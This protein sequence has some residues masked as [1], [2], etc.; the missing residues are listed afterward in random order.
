[1]RSVAPQAL[2]TD[3]SAAHRP[4]TEIRLGIV[5][6]M[7]NEAATAVRFVE[8]V[9]AECRRHELASVTFFAILDT[10]SSDNTRTLLERHQKLEGDLAVV[11]APETRGVSDAYQRGYR[12]ALAAD[13]DWILEIDAGFSHDPADIAAFLTTMAD[14]YDCVLGSRFIPG[15]KDLAATGRRVVS[16]CGTALTNAVLGTRLTDMTSGFE[17]FSRA[18]LEKVLAKGISAKGPFFQTEIKVHCRNLRIAEV[19]IR[20]SAGSHKVGRRAIGESL[21]ILWRLFRLR[22]GGTL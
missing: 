9:L 18:A 20:Y 7:A 15:G 3:L 12:E 21:A 10:V 1:M 17:L 5:C 14:G 2:T 6:P 11:W 16:R 22:L 19:P 4:V 13:C 8:T